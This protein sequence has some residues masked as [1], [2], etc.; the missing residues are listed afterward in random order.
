MNR[1]NRFVVFVSAGVLG[2][3]AINA[4]LVLAVTFLR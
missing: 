1:T 3:L 2:L 4:L